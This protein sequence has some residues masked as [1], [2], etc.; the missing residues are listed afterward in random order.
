[1]LRT[2]LNVI[3]QSWIG[4]IPA[5]LCG[6]LWLVGDRELHRSAA[7]SSSLIVVVGFGLLLI[8]ALGIGQQILLVGRKNQ[9][10]SALATGTFAMRIIVA[11]LSALVAFVVGF[12]VELLLR[13]AGEPTWGTAL[14]RSA[15][16]SLAIFS[17]FTS[18]VVFHV[19][20]DAEC[21]V[22]GQQ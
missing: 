17:L 19:R 15:W 4:L 1:M 6:V 21:A 12:A 2:R 13:T 7:E 14:L 11:V 16:H 18:P 10:G 22:G 20:G 9:S 5:A 3:V 8:S